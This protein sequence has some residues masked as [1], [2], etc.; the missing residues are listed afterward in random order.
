MISKNNI[1]RSAKTIKQLINTCESYGKFDNDGNLH[2][3]VE[4]TCFPSAESGLLC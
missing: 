1:T 3:P 2:L 4:K